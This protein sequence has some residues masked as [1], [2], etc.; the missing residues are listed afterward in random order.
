M[1]TE[2]SMNRFARCIVPAVILQLGLHAASAQTL[3][4]MDRALD[5]AIRNSPTMQQ[6]ELSLVRSQ[7]KL[8]AQ[9]ARLKSQFALVLNPFEYD[10]TNRFDR[11]TSEWFL[12]E[13]ASSSGTFA[14]NQRILPT[15]GTVA[16]RNTFS[17]DFN[18]SESAG[19]T[20]PISKTWN[21]RLMLEV[22]QPIFTYNRTK[23]ELER[24]ELSYENTLL[25]YLLQKLSL[26]RMVAQ[27]FYNVYSQQMRLNIANEELRN[28]EDSHEI[29]QNK[30]DG[31]LLALEELYQSEVNLATSRSSVYNAELNLENAIDE[32]KVIIGMPLDEDFELVTI[33]KADTV[34]VD[35][36]MAIAHALENRME[37][38]QREIDIENTLFSL[39]DAKTVNEFAGSVTA[40]FGV[41]SN[42]QSLSALFDN[43]TTT[44]AVGLTLNIPIFDWGE[45]KSEIRAAEADMESAQIDLEVEKTDIQVNIR[46]LVRSLRNLENQ[47]AIQE[48][49]VEN[50]QL[51]YEINLERY[52][53][54]DLTSLDLG[55]YQNQLSDRKMAL[56]N[57]II[58]HKLEMLNLKIQA[59]YDFE[60]ETSIVP[61][62][63][64]KE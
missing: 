54:G 1:N 62:E 26:E 29:I 20:D 48:K 30:V 40:S 44:P 7:E 46:A 25:R 27:S 43:S 17:Y 56:T 42:N 36:A 5:I 64:I 39:M 11:R 28:N 23:V 12:N 61:K 45:R 60:T 38:R 53:N 37:L 59:L 19:A 49:T 47:I 57:A 32:M 6:V 10:R 50:A 22:T 24:V 34:D 16:L 33:I 3:L 35:A 8:N 52:R 14:I 63:V 18:N 51:T 15:D 55:I 31:G 13:S 9:R 58:D 41:T 4:D 21:N 2:K